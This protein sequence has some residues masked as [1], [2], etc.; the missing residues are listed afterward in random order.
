MTV[1][2]FTTKVEDTHSGYNTATGTY[3]VPVSGLYQVE[4][5]VLIQWVSGAVA[6]IA[7][8]IRVNGV[9]KVTRY[10]SETRTQSYIDGGVTGTVRAKAGDT[11]T[12]ISSF[13]GTT[14]SVFS[15]GAPYNRVAITRIGN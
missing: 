1:I 14:K 9:D 10:T 7:Y 15:S 3:T 2:P 8:V 11:I 4:A 12:F 5:S 6:D 13:S